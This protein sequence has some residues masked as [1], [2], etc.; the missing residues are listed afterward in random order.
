MADQFRDIVA[1]VVAVLREQ[2]KIDARRALQ[3][4]HHLLAQP[5]EALPLNEIIPAGKEEDVSGNAYGFDARERDA[6][7]A[8]FERA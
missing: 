4:Y 8:A 3:R 6:S 1:R 2:R 5:D 7:Q